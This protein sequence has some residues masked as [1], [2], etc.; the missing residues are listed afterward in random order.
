MIAPT[1]AIRA[2]P[3]GYRA[4]ARALD[5]NDQ[6]V[7]DHFR[8]GTLPPGI[9]GSPLARIR[10]LVAQLEHRILELPSHGKVVTGHLRR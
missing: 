3:Q 5:L 6:Q 8:R 2:A 9:S 10:N 4:V 1:S 7:L